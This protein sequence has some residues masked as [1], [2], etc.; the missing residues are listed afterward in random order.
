MKE[1][2][3]P[4][5]LASVLKRVKNDVLIDDETAYVR[6]TI[7][8]NGKGIVPRDRVQ[9]NQ[10]GTKRQFIA[11]AGQLVLSKIDARN[12]AFG[13]LP[14]ECD[15]AII[16]GNFWAFDVDESQLL[17]RFLD[18]LTKTPLFIDFCIRASEGTTNRRYLQ[19]DK[20]LM[21]EINLPGL[22]VQQR[23]IGVL[24]EISLQ[25]NEIRR[26]RQ[27]SPAE[28]DALI[29]SIHH[30]LAGNRTRKLGE[31]L[32][33]SEDAVTVNSMDAYPQVGLRSFGAGLFPK[34]PISGTATMYR[35]FNRLHGGALI[36]SQVNGWEG[37]IAVCTPELDGWFVSPEYRSFRCIPNDARPGYLATLVTTEWFWSRLANVT[38]GV[39]ARRE[40][41]RPEQ[42]L[43]IELPMPDVEHQVRGE[44]L[45]AEIC[46]L[47]K[48]QN[49]TKV[50]LND[51][52]PS[53]L[54]HALA[55]DLN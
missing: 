21:Q 5:R 42:F 45:F 4:V 47:K 54:S 23:I 16:T 49:D 24:D 37:A 38:R 51:L 20:F 28:T 52:L 50:N 34:A 40:R 29:V 2:C 30:Q 35:A 22:P 27:E 33:L 15:R 17:T 48:L 55:S 1:H 19:E 41:T 12:G 31:I 18:Y 39:G 14:A 13:I 46:L 53:V 8:M 9:G 26:L 3:L 43:E 36:L 25:T 11:R 44:E 6:L 32:E 10:I 7:R